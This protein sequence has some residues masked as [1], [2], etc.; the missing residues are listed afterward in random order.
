[1]R[2]ILILLLSMLAFNSLSQ[3]LMFGYDFD[4]DTI[5]NSGNMNTLESFSTGPNY[6]F[7][8]GYS[9]NTTDS[10]IHFMEGI[11]LKSTQTF[12]NVGWDGTA[13]T[14]WIKAGNDNNGFVIQS[15]T[16]F[17]IKISVDNITCF[18]AGG[19]ATSMTS[20]M[21]NLD[22]GNWHHIVCQNNG[23]NSTIYID[24]ILNASQVESLF[25]QASM[26]NFYLGSSVT[27][28]D[29]ISSFIDD[30]RIYDDTLTQVQIDQ[31]T[32][33]TAK[34]HQKELINITASPNPTS[35]KV[36]INTT[37][38]ITSVQLFNMTGSL[39]LTQSNQVLDISNLADGIYIIKVSTEYGTA[40]QRIIKQ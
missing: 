5:D 10:C 8:D 32:G 7:D 33:L 16:G 26:V 28:Q 15:G 21:G 38:Q 30:L 27:N 23:S 19:S 35:G 24:G 2:T 39:L 20:T 40:E 18:F 25:A 37:A 4:G 17:G 12:N 14:F 31:I 1:M 11:G 22:D 34:L 6:S 13:V 36:V 9:G 3:T 29:K